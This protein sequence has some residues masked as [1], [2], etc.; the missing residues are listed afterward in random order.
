[1]GRYQG[2]GVGRLGAGWADGLGT[3]HRAQAARCGASRSA[4]LP[5]LCQVMRH[6][7]GR[8]PPGRVCRRDVAIMHDRA[9]SLAGAV[10]CGRGSQQRRAD[11]CLTCHA[12]GTVHTRHP[13]CLAHCLPACLPPRPPPCLPA[14]LAGRLPARTHASRRSVWC[15]ALRCSPRP[16]VTPRPRPA[17]SS[18]STSP[19]GAPTPATGGWAVVRHSGACCARACVCVC[20]SVRL[21]PALLLP[22]QPR[23]T[24]AVPA[25]GMGVAPGASYCFVLHPRVLPSALPYPA[26]PCHPAPRHQQLP[27]R[28]LPPPCR[29]NAAR[30]LLP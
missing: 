27:P 6:A 28:P 10:Q 25:A 16:R 11:V 12:R 24:A 21:L 1:M 20:V 9:T 7:A 22:S 3:S 18:A 29:G 17:S 23:R 5:Q 8:A 2:E 30:M 4:P 13:K 19:A 14:C 26:H 15:G